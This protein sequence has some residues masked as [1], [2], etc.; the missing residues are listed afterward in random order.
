MIF[1]NYKSIDKTNQYLL[2]WYVPNQVS[3]ECE[4]EFELFVLYPYPIV[5]V[6]IFELKYGK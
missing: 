6:F 4:F 2:W 1:I 3:V 5:F